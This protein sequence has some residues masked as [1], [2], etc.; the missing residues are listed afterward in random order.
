M[1][2]LFRQNI[3]IPLF[4]TFARKKINFSPIVQWFAFLRASRSIYSTKAKEEN[5]ENVKKIDNQL[6]LC[7]DPKPVYI[8]VDNSNIFIE[9][10][11]PIGMLEKIGIF[12][13]NRNSKCFNQFRIDHDLLLATVQ[14]KLDMALV[15]SIF[16]VMLTKKPG[17][18]ALVASDSDYESM[19]TLAMKHNWIV[20][21]WF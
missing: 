18:I 3:T 8:F 17:T 4:G 14:G 13:H 19:T 16:E 10:K 9:G 5:Q 20:E 21:T 15:S 11:Y 12:D 6:E 1:F 2:S 7:K